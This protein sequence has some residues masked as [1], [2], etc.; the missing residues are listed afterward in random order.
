M[1]L[2]VEKRVQF[3]EQYLNGK[4]KLGQVAKETEMN[5]ITLKRSC[6]IYENKAPY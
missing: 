3:V 5:P 6:A 2:N 1:K 4:L